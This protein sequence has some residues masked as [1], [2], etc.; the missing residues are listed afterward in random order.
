M[1]GISGLVYTDPRHPV[2][3]DLMRR[4]TTTLAHRGPDADGFFWGDGAALGHRRLSIIDLSTGDQP[5]FNEDRSM[6]VG[7]NGVID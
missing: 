3:R 5:I 6:V 2:D 1:C 4:L 7:S